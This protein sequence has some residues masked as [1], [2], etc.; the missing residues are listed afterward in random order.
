MDSAADMDAFDCR[1]YNDCQR[2]G[3]QSRPGE[4][5]MMRDSYW[6]YASM[7]RES[8]LQRRLRRRIGRGVGRGMRDRPVL[9]TILLAV[10]L[11]AVICL[12]VMLIALA[13]VVAVAAL[14]GMAALRIGRRIASRQPHLARYPSARPAAMTGSGT[15]TLHRYLDATEE[16]GRLSESLLAEPVEQPVRSKQVREAG[17]EARRLQR[18][19]ESLRSEWRGTA[20][21]GACLDEL[22]NASDAL[23]RYANALQARGS[24][25]LSV[26]ELGWQRDDLARRRDHL[27]DR[28]RATDFRGGETAAAGAYL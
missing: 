7:L 20:D 19:A 14:A 1:G 18:S 11:A 23:G 10:A 22:A 9:T 27:I 17:A 8:G 25:R 3:E 26:A 28:L 6:G 5:T 15:D 4:M 2:V 24:R 21:I 16:F 12:V 13:A